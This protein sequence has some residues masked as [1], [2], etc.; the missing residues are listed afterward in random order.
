MPGLDLKLSVLALCNCS[1]VASFVRIWLRFAFCCGGPRALAKGE[2]WV[3]MANG[4]RICACC[5]I[6]IVDWL[7]G[8]VLVLIGIGKFLL[9]TTDR[10]VKQVFY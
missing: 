9:L 2:V 8:G 10:A 7:L 6:V 5:L 1:V 4:P 3:L